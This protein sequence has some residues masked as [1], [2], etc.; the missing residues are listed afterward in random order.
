MMQ[1]FRDKKQIARRK[2]IT[3]IGVFV[4]FLIILSTSFFLFGASAFLNTIGRPIWLAKNAVVG[5]FH[6]IVDDVRS[7]SALHQENTALVSEN[8]TLVSQMADYQIVKNENIA[9]KELMGRVSKSH[10][11]VLANILAKPDL[12]PYDTI[13]IDAGAS[14]GVVAGHTVY[15]N[16]SFPI[17]EVTTVYTDT[18]LVTLY[19]NP[20]KVT[21][22]MLDSSNNSI[23]LTGRGG[24]NFEMKIPQESIANH[25]QFVVLPNSHTVTPEIIAIVEE[26]TANPSDPYQTVLLRSP[27]NVQDLK[28]VE[29]EKD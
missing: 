11:F 16:G 18:S 1:Q 23:E 9:L 2:V 26:A 14:L 8:A 21:R 29:V 28:W 24:G 3:W 10:S 13:I 27:V 22:A 7:K 25:G 19:S 6:N 5:F 15:G 20:G 17:G 4:V 12:S